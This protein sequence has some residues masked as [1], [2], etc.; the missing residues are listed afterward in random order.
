VRQGGTIHAFDAAVAPRPILQRL[1][2]VNMKQAQHTFLLPL[3][4]A[5]ILVA[6]APS[7]ASNDMTVTETT[8]AAVVSSAF[9]AWASQTG[10]VF[11]ILSPDVTWT[12]PGSGPVAGTYIGRQSFLEDASLPLVNRLATPI[13]PEVHHIWA[14]DDRVIIRFDGTAT[15]TSGAPY[16]NQFVWIFRMEDGVVVEAEAFLDL[17]A[18]QAVLE[19]NEPRAE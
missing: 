10:S 9:E 1:K 19:N 18:Y 3:V 16:A 17:V 11:D 13:V 7:W 12:I 2:E 6:A 14:S 5:S 8:N 15:T 4:A